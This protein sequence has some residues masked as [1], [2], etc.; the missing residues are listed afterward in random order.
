MALFAIPDETAVA[1]R[2]NTVLTILLLVLEL[3]YIFVV[4]RTVV[5]LVF[6]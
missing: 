2:G 5:L 6:D 1:V 4:Q 3:S